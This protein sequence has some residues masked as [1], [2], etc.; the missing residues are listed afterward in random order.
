MIQHASLVA[1][2]E[3]IAAVND[4]LNA[5][6]V[7]TWDSRTMMPAGGAETRGHQIATLTR[8]ARDLLLAPETERALEGAERAVE[9][10]AEDSFKERVLELLVLPCQ[11]YRIVARICRLHRLERASL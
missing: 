10:L 6:S 9:G 11:D 5:T 7:L 3:R 4:V 2:Q 8:I 1:L